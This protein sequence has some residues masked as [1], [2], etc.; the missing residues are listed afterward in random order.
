MCCHSRKT[1]M[2]EFKTT[3]FTVRALIAPDDDLDLSW[4]DGGETAENLNSGLWEAFETEVTVSF[5][6][7]EIG[8]DYLG[9]SIY[10]KPSEFFTDHRSPDPMNRNCSIMRAARGDKT[11]IGHYFPDMVRNAISEARKAL[12]AVPKMRAA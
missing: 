9:G 2:W 12:A 8:A 6:G 1:V 4:D 10:E 7:A 5:R 11:S 3:N